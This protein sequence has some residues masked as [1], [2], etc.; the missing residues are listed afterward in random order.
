MWHGSSSPEDPGRVSFAAEISD[1]FARALQAAV[2]RH[3]ET[4]RELRSALCACVG[5]LKGR[6]MPSEQ[7]L[8]VIKEH[9]RTTAITHPPGG[10][11]GSRAAADHLM[12]DIVHW[13]IVEYYRPA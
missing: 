9:V 7:V 1:R 11:G 4:M 3:D 13:C 6:G 12:D 5:E 10:Q 2:R 8:A